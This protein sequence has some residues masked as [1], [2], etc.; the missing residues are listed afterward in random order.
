MT[1]LL[2][3]TNPNKLREMRPWLSGTD[4]QVVTLAD[5]PPV[6]E[7]EETS[8]TFW[9]TAREKALAYAGAT[10]LTAVAEDSGLAVD[11]LGGEPGVRSAR[12]LSPDASYPV[13][14]AEI[15]RR[16]AGIPGPYTARFVTAVAVAAGGEILFETEAR[17]EG[18]L[19]D[20]ARGELGFGY[21][22]V[23]LYPPFA[24]TTGEMPLEDKAAISHRARA[25]RDLRRAIVA[26][27]LGRPGG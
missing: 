17:V 2:A 27:A 10:G 14:F 21:D 20:S 7:P 3:T 9:E 19:A 13:R 5:I 1:L 25:F 12:F 4:V 8:A 11:A 24:R 15:Y 23:F 16:L 26:G 22:P 18:V 6:P